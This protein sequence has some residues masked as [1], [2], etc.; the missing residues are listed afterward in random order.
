VGNEINAAVKDLDRAAVT[1]L[2]AF[3][4][5]Y[6]VGMSHL[7][8]QILYHILNQREDIAAERVFAP[9]ID[10]EAVLRERNLPL[11]SLESRHPAGRFDIIG[12]SLQYEL[13]Y[14]NV[15]TMLDLAGIPLHWNERTREHPLIIAGGPCTFNPEPVADFFDALVVG[16][17]EEVILELINVYQ[18]WRK[19]REERRELLS[20]L[21]TIPGVYVPARLSV[22]YAPDGTIAACEPIQPSLVPVMKRVVKDLNVIDYPVRFIVP[23][24]TIVHDRINIEI[25]R[26]CSRG[27]RFCQAGMI[28]RPVRERSRTNVEGLAE[29]ACRA[30]GWE[31][32]SL[33][34]LSSGDYSDIEQLLLD[35]AETHSLRETALSFPSLRAETLRGALIDIIRQGRNTG[36]T[37]APEAGTERL[38]RFINKGLTEGEVVETCRR[39]YS[40]GWQNI[41][42]YFMLGLPTETEEDLQ[43]I[44]D[45][46]ERIWSQG[47]GLNRK[48]QA[49]ISV[50]TFIP[51]PH[52]PFQWAGMINAAEIGKRHKYLASRL[53]RGRFHFKWHDAKVSV[54]EGVMSR[55]D[56]R[57]SKV[58]ETAF[59][60][61]CRF[62]GWSDQFRSDLWEHAFQI[63]EINPYQYLQ[64]R[65]RDERLPWDHIS[66]GVTKDYLWNEYQKAFREEITPDCRFEECRQCGVCD[67]V[68]LYPR[69]TAPSPEKHRSVAS[70]PEFSDIVRIRLGFSKTGEARILSHLEMV[71]VFAR[72]ARR[73][74]IPLRYSQ[75]YHPQPRIVFGPALPLGMKSLLEYVDLELEKYV[76][77]E[78]LCALLDRE[79]PQGIR[80]RSSKEIP[81]KMLAI[82]DSLYETSYRVRGETEQVFGRCS[83]SEA[84]AVVEDFF[85]RTSYPLTRIRNGKQSIVDLRHVLKQITIVDDREVSLVV[86]IVPGMNV[87]PAEIMTAL[88]GLSD[89]ECLNLD[90]TK[91]E[92]KLRESWVQS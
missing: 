92:M 13:S 10:M 89:V 49:T 58:I 83:I 9:W 76:A 59:R 26:G 33:L 36:F 80:I 64:P 72:A 37:I 88:F 48:N 17:G 32:L 46:A 35:L 90:I 91:T 52:T 31:E 85:R 87:R 62:D 5:V 27:C 22:A 77:P 51:K 40:A 34:S 23:Y 43:G 86:T 3:P 63:N 75:G 47:K 14:T 28:G 67:F 71:R 53:R 24:N 38:R 79:L 60:L 66:C 54:L 84:N 44:I 57:L 81:L 82:S 65:S 30:T 55:G 2:L 11:L 50:S 18:T 29:A 74:K 16:E 78:E 73:A 4:D 25:A 19:G 42:L 56:R 6:E 8:L 69:L 20:M 7:G 39:V 45:L 61:G 21:S 15:L 1:V 68:S 41:K 70:P 12:F